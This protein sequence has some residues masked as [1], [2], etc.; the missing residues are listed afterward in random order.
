MHWDK[1][2]FF[3]ALVFFVIEIFIAIYV[4]DKIIRP[5]LGD[6]FVVILIY[7]FLKA[8]INIRYIKAALVVWIF[9]VIVEISQ[10]LEF[11]KILGFSNSEIGKAVLGNS[12][13]WLDI[14]MYSIGTLLIVFVEWL[15][16]EHVKK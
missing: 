10:H 9:A 13:S 2:Y 5:F 12:F 4:H 16:R 7:A 11:I 14:L 8:F 6:L 3:L 15:R 1:K